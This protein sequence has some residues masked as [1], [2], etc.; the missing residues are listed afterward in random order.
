VNIKSLLVKDY[1]CPQLPITL[2]TPTPEQKQ[3][4]SDPEELG[5]GEHYTKRRSRK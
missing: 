5:K 3:Q 2:P 1:R 4:P